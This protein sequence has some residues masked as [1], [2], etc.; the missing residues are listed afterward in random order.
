MR[1]LTYFEAERDALRATNRQLANANASLNTQLDELSTLN[2]LLTV[3]RDDARRQRDE[4][5]ALVIAQRDVS[6]PAVV[7]VDREDDLLTVRCGGMD[8]AVTTEEA[9]LVVTALLADGAVHSA[10]LHGRGGR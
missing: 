8:L 5:A 1:P 3:E 10:W 2:A 4:C 7:V 6:E 9:L